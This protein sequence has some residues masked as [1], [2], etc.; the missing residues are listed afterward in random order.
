MTL[1]T[2]NDG[3]YGLFRIMG[4]AGFISFTVLRSQG[5]G[6][7]GSELRDQ[8]SGAVRMQQ[9]AE[10]QGLSKRKIKSQCSC[11]P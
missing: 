6:K 8:K 9:D 2:L 3:I 10:T 7:Q 4:D 1:R 11:Y 5:V